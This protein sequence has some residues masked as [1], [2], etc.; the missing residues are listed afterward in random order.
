[1]GLEQGFSALLLA[2]EA[3]TGL[4]PAAQHQHNET[5]FL[6]DPSL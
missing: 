3:M 4:T 5:R 6:H 2:V 1:M